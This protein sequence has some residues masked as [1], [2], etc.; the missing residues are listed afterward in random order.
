MSQPKIDQL[1]PPLVGEGHAAKLKMYSLTSDEVVAQMGTYPKKKDGDMIIGTIPPTLAILETRYVKDVK[2]I[3]ELKTLQLRA[4][5]NQEY[6]TGTLYTEE[7]AIIIAKISIIKMKFNAL[8]EQFYSTYNFHALSLRV[9]G[10]VV[11]VALE[12]EP[13]D[14]DAEISI[15]FPPSLFPR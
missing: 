12:K 15:V 3:N 14:N 8:S 4:E 6:S 1:F 7:A 2:R 5:L 13:I 11:E 10:M 9:N